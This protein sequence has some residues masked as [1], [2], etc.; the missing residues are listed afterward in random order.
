MNYSLDTD[1]YCLAELGEMKVYVTSYEVFRDR[2]YSFFNQSEVGIY[3]S[4]NGSY[5][6]YLKIK[7]F[8]LKSECSSPCVLFNDHM[9]RNMRYFLIL[10]GIY[11]N[12][13]RLK[14][15]SVVTDK[16]SSVI[17][18]EVILCCDSY[19]NEITEET[20]EDA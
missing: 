16:N 8:I 9:D 12:A 19:M 18:C 7:G 1:N 15:Y 3:F 6:A 5:P 11:F 10:D 4:D 2:R 13:A 14:K 20:Q 17:E